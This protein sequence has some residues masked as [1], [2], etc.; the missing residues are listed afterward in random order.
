MNTTE[1]TIIAIDGWTAIGI[2]SEPLAHIAGKYFF[3]YEERNAGSVP[4]WTQN[5]IGTSKNVANLKPRNHVTGRTDMFLYKDTA[6]VTY[7]VI[8]E[9]RVW[10]VNATVSFPQRAVWPHVETL[11]HTWALTERNRYDEHVTVGFVF[12][13]DYIYQIAD[14][15]R[16][17]DRVK[18]G[19]SS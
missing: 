16:A 11:P 5:E 14:G 15:K 13:D 2:T 12:Y 17:Y 7:T 4:A 6:P 9:D 10:K 18:T 8:A 1:A 3:M 19:E